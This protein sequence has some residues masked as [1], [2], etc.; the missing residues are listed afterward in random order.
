MKRDNF[1][2]ILL[3][4]V[5]IFLLS[6]FLPGTEG[7]TAR[8]E[9]DDILLAVVY[10][11]ED[12]DG[13]TGYWQG[14]ELAI[15]EINSKG[16]IAG[17]D[18]EVIKLDDRGSVT[19][20]LTIAR[21]LVARGEVTAVIGHW[22]SRVSVP[23]ATVYNDAGLIMITPAST[24]PQISAAG[25]Q[26]IFQQ[27]MDDSQIGSEIASFISGAGFQRVA[28][29]YADDDYGRGL[30]N[31]FSRSARDMGLRMVDRLS[32]LGS[33]LDV[34]R[35]VRKWEALDIE[36]LLVADVLPQAGITIR[37]L[38]ESGL[39][40]PVI[41]ATGLD[42]IAYLENFAGVAEG[43][44]VTTL[45]NPH[46][47]YTEVKNFVELYQDKYGMM[48]DSWAAQ[49]YDT[50]IILQAAIE[51]AGSSDAD[52]IAVALRELKDWPG[53]TG[54]LSFNP[55]GAVTGKE[56]F[57]KEVIEGRFHYLS[58]HSSVKGVD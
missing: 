9:N 17:K 39:E 11:V 13:S 52:S 8:A 42:R 54:R 50:V 33:E 5:L 38:R 22:N 32:V 43:S 20:G 3:L 23:A 41:G 26:Y 31:S 29:I 37:R 35:T 25:H 16:G 18:V 46:L 10:P 24:S 21:S 48:P 12:I 58:G 14:I 7:T 40:I 47:D 4:S 53:V 36:I 30:V 2:L 56:I 57:F 19:E 45:F 44:Y 1:F 49:A 51:D 55:Q 28:A 15:E 27:V 6:A 34:E